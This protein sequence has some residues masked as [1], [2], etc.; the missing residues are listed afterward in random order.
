MGVWLTNE[1]GTTKTIGIK[2]SET[3]RAPFELGYRA[4]T[5]PNVPAATSNAV[6][7]GE[8]KL[9]IEGGTATEVK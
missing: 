6:F 9:E 8:A 1:T 5:C 3:N 7:K 2:Y 4:E